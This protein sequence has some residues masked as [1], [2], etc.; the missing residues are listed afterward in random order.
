MLFVFIRDEMKEIFRI[1]DEKIVFHSVHAW[2]EDYM[3][4]DVSTLLLHLEFSPVF[5]GLLTE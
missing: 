2:L 4:L 1:E 5:N 3:L